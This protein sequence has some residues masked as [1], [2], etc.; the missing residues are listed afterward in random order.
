MDR[1]SSV[2]TATASAP[3]PTPAAR[4]VPESARRKRELRDLRYDPLMPWLITVEAA[5]ILASKAADGLAS[6]RGRARGEEPAPVAELSRET[7]AA[8]AASRK[9]ARENSVADAAADADAEAALAD[10]SAA[11]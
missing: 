11:A 5:C 6:R 2:S 8:A 10:A 4:R 9:T 3:G 7:S 1:V